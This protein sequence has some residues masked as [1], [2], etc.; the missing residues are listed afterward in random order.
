[1]G[2]YV[3][4]GEYGPEI[5]LRL[6]ALKLRYPKNICLLRGNHES[7][8]QTQM[9]NFRQQCV[10]LY[11]SEFYDTVMETFDRLPLAALVNGLYLCM[12]GGI[13]ERIRTVDDINL[14]DRKQE[15]PEDEHLMNDL[16]WADPAKGSEKDIDYAENT[17]RNMSVFFGKNPVN[18]LLKRKGL[19]S[20]IRAHE[21]KMEGI[22][23]HFWNGED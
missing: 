13:S 18:K 10:D 4:R 14:I 5:V 3:D 6:F 21:V 22:K 20:M 2:D 17:T 9:F 8:H 12:H 15:P 19:R 1:M 11:D 7:R 16:L 23:Q